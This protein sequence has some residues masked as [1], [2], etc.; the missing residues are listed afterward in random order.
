MITVSKPSYT[1]VYDVGA[2]VS[3]LIGYR[4]I[5]LSDISKTDLCRKWEKLQR[6]WEYV[7]TII[8]ISFR[9]GIRLRNNIWYNLE[10]VHTFLS[11][12][13]FFLSNKRDL[14]LGVLDTGEIYLFI[15]LFI[16]ASVLIFCLGALL[17]RN[18]NGLLDRIPLKTDQ[19][20]NVLARLVI[21]KV[22]CVIM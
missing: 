2:I 4:S 13:M 22:A 6:Q 10:D 11:N 17:Q 16:T 19:R 8:N 3:Q 1:A 18:L 9:L 20:R 14:V 7:I 12:T 21:M 5:A 15:F